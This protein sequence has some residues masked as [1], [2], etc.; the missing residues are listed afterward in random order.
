MTHHP[1]LHMIVPGGGI[2][3][4]GTRWVPCRPG[5]LLPV[6]VLSA[7]THPA[8][9]RGLKP[10]SGPRCHDAR[11]R[12]FTTPAR[13][14]TSRPALHRCRPAASQGASLTFNQP[15]IAASTAAAT[16]NLASPS[17]IRRRLRQPAHALPRLPSPQ[18]P[19]TATAR[20]A[21]RGSF[22]GGFRTPALRARARSYLWA[23][24]RNASP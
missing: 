9:R 6:R 15:K 5:F 7:A 10:G 1:H 12:L 3:L 24:I 14:G 20:T 13:W 17:T 11:H 4:D 16:I 21:S 19:I 2:S 22:L 23:G 8:A 18:I